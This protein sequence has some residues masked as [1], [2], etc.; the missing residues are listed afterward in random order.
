MIMKSTRG[1]N[2][3]WLR[4]QCNS[5]TIGRKNENLEVVKPLNRRTVKLKKFTLIELLVVIAIIAILA[6]MLLPALKSAREMAKQ[7]LCAN[8]L[9]QIGLA[10]QFY[11]GDYNEYYSPFVN[12]LYTYQQFVGMFEYNDTQG[13]AGWGGKIYPYLGGR[14]RWQTYVCPSDLVPRD[15]SDTSSNGG[16]G[17]GASYAVNS[18]ANSGNGGIGFDYTFGGAMT[19]FYYR[20]SQAMWPSDSCLVSELKTVPPKTTWWPYGLMYRPWHGDIYNP[21]HNKSVN[22]LYLDGHSNSINVF[23]GYF[24]GANP[25]NTDRGKFWFIRW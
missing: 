12:S 15:L 16:H 8:N 1:Q 24:V 14:G 13:N 19:T 10:Y 11:G 7:S 23:G 4:G 6:A 20:F 21:V 18:G 9:K 17:T 25:C 3:S 22:V 5:T 2:D